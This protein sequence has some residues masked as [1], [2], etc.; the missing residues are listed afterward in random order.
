MFKFKF[1]IRFKQILSFVEKT[2]FFISLSLE[3]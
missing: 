2:K 1:K 3:G